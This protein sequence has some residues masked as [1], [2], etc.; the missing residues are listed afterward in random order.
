MDESDSDCVYE[1]LKV[2]EVN[3]ELY[4]YDGMFHC[5]QLLPFLPESRDAY[6]KV[7]NRIRSIINELER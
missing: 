1:K 6:K 5:F 3:A 7:F 4:K 2:A